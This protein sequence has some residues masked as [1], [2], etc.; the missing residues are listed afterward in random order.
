MPKVPTIQVKNKDKFDELVTRIAEAKS[1]IQAWQKA[2]NHYQE[3]MLT[4]FSTYD[5]SSD[6]EGVEAVE[7]E[8]YLVKISHKLTRSVDKAKAEETAKRLGVS[9]GELYNVKYDFSKTIYNTLNDAQ[10]EAVL[11]TVITKRAKASFDI[12]NKEIV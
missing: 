3:E 6:F 8:K 11:E 12:S 2:L 9:T 7:S 4:T 1:A 10:K 5:E